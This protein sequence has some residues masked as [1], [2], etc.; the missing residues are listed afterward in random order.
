MDEAAEQ[1]ERLLPQPGVR[2]AA[3]VDDEVDRFEEHRVVGVGLVHLWPSTEKD[4]V[5][6][7]ALC[8][9][10]KKK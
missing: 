8:Y 4:G 10:D 9:E 2:R 5:A 6:W 7:W 1:R 3:L